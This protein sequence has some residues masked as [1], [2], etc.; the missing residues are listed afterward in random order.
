[1]LVL[2]LLFCVQLI[3]KKILTKY[4]YTHDIYN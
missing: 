4:Y 2:K 1:M 3:I